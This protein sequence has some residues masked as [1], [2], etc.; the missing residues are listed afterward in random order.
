MNWEIIC[1]AL[2]GLMLVPELS[3]QL[4]GTRCP[5]CKSRLRRTGLTQIVPQ[6]VFK[7]WH[8][9]RCGSRFYGEPPHMHETAA[10]SES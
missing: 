4:R 1:C 7:T 10:K 9:P 3:R 8:C 2:F 5:A 6:G